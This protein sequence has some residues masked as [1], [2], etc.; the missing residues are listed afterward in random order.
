MIRSGSG[1]AT[2]SWRRTF[3]P[4]LGVTLVGVVV[5]YPIEAWSEWWVVLVLLLVLL[6]LVWYGGYRWDKYVQRP[7]EKWADR[8]RKEAR[9]RKRRDP[10]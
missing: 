8:K 3:W 7:L 9:R 1:T 2:S 6:P 10:H 5:G 4:S